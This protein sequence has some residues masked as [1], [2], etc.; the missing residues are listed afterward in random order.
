MAEKNRAWNPKAKALKSQT[1]CKNGHPFDE[2]NTYYR[3]D[4]PEKMGRICKA[5][6]GIRLKV[7]AEKR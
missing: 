2:K 1:S 3:K 5:C 6:R 4:R 7:Y